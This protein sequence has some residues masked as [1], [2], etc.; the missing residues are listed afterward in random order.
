MR[1]VNL[2]QELKYILHFP[3][4]FRH[5]TL[6]CATSPGTRV[7][8]EMSFKLQPREC[9]SLFLQPF[10]YMLTPKPV[11]FL[12]NFMLQLK[13]HFLQTIF[14]ITTIVTLPHPKRRLFTL[15]FCSFKFYTSS[16]MVF[17]T[18]NYNYPRVFHLDYM[19][20]STWRPFYSMAPQWPSPAG[21]H[22]LT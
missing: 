9:F 20:W 12:L 4:L 19:E 21:V 5:R 1:T 15:V 6:F 2:S 14:K 18:E 16:F 13:C 8:E 22:A 3:N 17:I 7:L 11:Q 10:F